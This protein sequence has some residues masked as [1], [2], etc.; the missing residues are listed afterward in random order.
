[1]YYGYGYE[2]RGGWS[3]Y[4]GAAARMLFAAYQLLGITVQDGIVR[5]GGDLFEPKGSLQVHRLIYKGVTYQK[6]GSVL[7]NN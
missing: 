7:S 3:W 1:V 2:G 6:D 5:I 4:T